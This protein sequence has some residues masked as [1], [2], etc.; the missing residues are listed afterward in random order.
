MHTMCDKKG[1]LM[2]RQHLWR[3]G[4]WH[5]VLLF[6]LLTPFITGIATVVYS[7]PAQ[8]AGN[9]LTLA[10]VTAAA[11]A[12]GSFAITLDNSDAVA[13]GQVRFTYAASL[14]MTIT[15]VQVTSRTTGFTS[16]ISTYNTGNASLTGYQVLF[17][18][19]S[20][21]TIAPGSGAILTLSYTL[22]ANASGNTTLP[23]TQAILANPAA[24]SLPVTTVDGAFT[25]TQATTPTVTPSATA[26]PT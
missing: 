26:T 21:L 24:Q 9:T 13:S 18:N 19:L 6:S 15:G 1:T 3:N 25:V 17:Y 14:G 4:Y 12:S 5:L 2:K 23:F 10:T 11:G 8:A 7:L 16:T 22:A 20:S